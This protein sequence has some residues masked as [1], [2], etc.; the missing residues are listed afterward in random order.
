G[1]RAGA[2][3]GARG[4]A[5]GAPPGARAEGAG[6]PRL[7]RRASPGVA[8]PPTASS[9]AAVPVDP[10]LADVRQQLAQPARGAVDRA[11]RAALAAYYAEPGRELLWVRADG[12]TARARHAMAEIRRAEDWGLNASAFDLPNL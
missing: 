1:R 11:D 6:S 10:I 7:A 4:A 2:V 5:G 9:E 8:P 12:F 3:A